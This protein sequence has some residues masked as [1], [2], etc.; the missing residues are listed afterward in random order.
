MKFKVVF[1]IITLFF[2]VCI[3]A[4]QKLFLLQRASDPNEMSLLGEDTVY[5]IFLNKECKSCFEFVERNIETIKSK[6]IK[7]V[8]SIYFWRQ[9]GPLLDQYSIAKKHHGV[10]FYDPGFRLEKFANLK[11]FKDGRIIKYRGFAQKPL[12]FNLT[13]RLLKNLTKKRKI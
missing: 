7:V 6:N 5:V 3:A 2:N 9:V 4:N 12:V 8:V 13:K 10:F 11:G 1:I